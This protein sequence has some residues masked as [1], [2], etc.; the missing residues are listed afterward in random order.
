MRSCWAA[1]FF[2]AT[3]SPKSVFR[4]AGVCGIANTSW[5]HNRSV[6]NDSMWPKSKTPQPQQPQPT[7]TTGMTGMGMRRQRVISLLA[8]EWS[9]VKCTASWR[10][11]VKG[12]QLKLLMTAW[13]LSHE[14]NRL[15]G[16]YN[17]CNKLCNSCC[18]SCIELPAFCSPLGHP[19]FLY[20]SH[21]PRDC[22]HSSLSA[23]VS[24]PTPSCCC[25][26]LRYCHSDLCATIF[27]TF[28]A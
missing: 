1:S 28:V 11:K 5:R 9:E 21:L 22:R 15:I 3:V 23:S 6:S 16:R 24:L 18:T 19:V 8:F 27:V 12:R 20:I 17:I 2:V 13:E 25:C 26:C 10:R 14:D 4:R 7:M